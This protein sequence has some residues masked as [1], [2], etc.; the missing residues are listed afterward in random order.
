MLD[1]LRTEAAQAAPR[2]CCGMLLGEAG[3]IT[4]IAPA[5]NVHPQPE[6]HFEIDPQALIDA[7][8][9]ARAG[10]PA[11]LGYYHSHPL[12]PAQPSATDRAE[13][14]HDGAIWAIV[15]GEGDVTFWR[16]DECGFTALPYPA[17][18]A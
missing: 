5:R 18:N 8:R 10:G 15:T 9:T 13:A 14:A 7:H 2:E 4:A 16:D 3:R 12:G 1:L 17:A 11:V 6:T